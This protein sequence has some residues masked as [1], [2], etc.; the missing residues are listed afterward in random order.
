MINYPL[1]C[2][3]GLWF[4]VLLFD[5][6]FLLLRWSVFPGLFDRLDLDLIFEI[7]PLSRKIMTEAKFFTRDSFGEL[8]IIVVP[9]VRF[10]L[11]SWLR[12]SCSISLVRCVPYSS[13]NKTL[14]S[15]S[16]AN[17]I[18]T[19]CSSPFVRLAIDLFHRCLN[20]GL[21]KCRFINIFDFFPYSLFMIVPTGS[22]EPKSSYP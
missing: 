14:G 16:K 19:Q 15:L 20:L 11:L 17:T 22:F 6:F 3:F 1:S 12:K 9:R 8:T 21:P 5:L 2:C 18:P 4:R 10:I 13:I 7:W